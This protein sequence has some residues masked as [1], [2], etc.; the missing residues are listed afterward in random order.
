MARSFTDYRPKSGIKWS[1]KV[2]L[3][4]RIFD[5]YKSQGN[6]V[7]PASGL[8]LPNME[9]GPI[10]ISRFG[11]LEINGPFTKQ[12]RDRG[13]CLLCD[14]L[15][16]GAAA[17]PHM[18]GKGAAGSSK[19][20]IQD[21]TIPSAITLSGHRTHYDDFA[22]WLRENGYA[23]F[24]PSL[25]TSPLPS[26]GDISADYASWPSRG[27][28]IVSAAGCG[29]AT[30]RRVASYEG[31]HTPADVTGPT[32]NAGTAAPGGAGG[33]GGYI[34]RVTN[35]WTR[36]C[37]GSVG[38]RGFPWGGGIG[39]AAGYIPGNEST[40]YAGVV[41]LNTYIGA[42]DGDPY[43]VIT[44]SRPGGVLIILVRRNITAASGHSITASATT[45]N[46]GGGHGGGRAFIARG[47]S[48]SGTLNMAANGGSAASYCGPGGA[49][50]VT[51]TTLA[52]M[53]W[54]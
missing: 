7:V 27:S 9:D 32:G 26:M 48:L 33:G 10:T 21:I 31:S 28:A 37:V 44:S 54:S 42:I 3:G 23:I 29:A 25:Y 12:Y 14:D 38:S 13:W 17:R 5:F 39:G 15:V 36:P 52:A 18:D 47:G 24:D 30:S 6:L 1:K 40:Y 16:L 22:D 2:S 11:T 49:G 45:E 50:A 53:G 20:A 43:S 8:V 19:W 34:G 4:S 35:G 41:T 46:I 51:S